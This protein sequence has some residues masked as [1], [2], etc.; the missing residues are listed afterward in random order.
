MAGIGLAGDEGDAR[1]SVDPVGAAV[2]DEGSDREP[3]ALALAEPGGERF[4]RVDPRQALTGV[5]IDRPGDDWEIGPGKQRRQRPPPARNLAQKPPPDP[6]R[7]RHVE[8]GDAGETAPQPL[9]SETDDPVGPVQD[10]PRPS[11]KRPTER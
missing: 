11:G 4:L 10:R 8:T 1:L 3:A 2:L 5:R 6:A 7:H 9:A